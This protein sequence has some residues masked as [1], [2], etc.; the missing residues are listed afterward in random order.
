MFCNN[1]CLYN[2]CAQCYSKARSGHQ[3]PLNWSYRWLSA[4]VWK[5]NLGP[6]EEQSVLT[7]SLAPLFVSLIP[8]CVKFGLPPHKKCVLLLSLT[9]LKSCFITR[10]YGFLLFLDVVSDISPLCF[11]P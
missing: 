1:V 7:V 2:M 5:S 9:L 10:L 6:L 3:I 11:H 4:T 8:C